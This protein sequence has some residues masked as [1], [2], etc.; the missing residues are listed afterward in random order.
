MPG[1]A[2]HRRPWSRRSTK[3]RCEQ[4]GERTVG[5]TLTAVVLVA[6]PLYFTNRTAAVLFWGLYAVWI[7][8][9]LVF[10]VRTLFR[11]GAQ[12]RDQGS[13]VI[14]LS[15]IFVGLVLSTT[16]VLAVP[17]AAVGEGRTAVFSAGLAIMVLGMALRFSAML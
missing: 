16:L 8:V 5:A 7:A 2:R 6:G 14:A 11:K 1:A 15:S 4:P 13:F 9:E 17:G 12:I 3:G 10:Y